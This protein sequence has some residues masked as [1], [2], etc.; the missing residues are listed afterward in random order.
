MGVEKAV[1]GELQRLG[2]R[3]IDNEVVSEVHAT[4]VV[5]KAGRAISYDICVWAGGMRVAPLAAATGL[6]TDPHGRIW[7]DPN[8]RSISHPNVLAVGDAAHPI[9]PTGAPY[10]PSSLPAGATGAY[11]AAVII[12]WRSQKTLEPFSF[13]TIAQAVAIGP[14]AVFFPLD[15]NDRQVSFI[16]KGRAARRLRDFLLL[17]VIFGFKVDRR[18]LRSFALPGRGRVSWDQANDAMQTFRAE[19]APFPLKKGA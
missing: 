9:A 17:T 16:L 5:T 15:A 12:A 18:F 10:R 7:V 1:R 13:S 19:R 11:A 8:L 3:L 2:V 6:E 14:F 4:E